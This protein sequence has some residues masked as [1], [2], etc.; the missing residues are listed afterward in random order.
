MLVHDYSTHVDTESATLNLIDERND[1]FER[2]KKDLESRIF[3]YKDQKPF[4][5]ASPVV[6]NQ[7]DVPQTP[8][9]DLSVDGGNQ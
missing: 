2:D 1:A 5:S 9:E 7:D 6:Q 8:S 3:L 4:H